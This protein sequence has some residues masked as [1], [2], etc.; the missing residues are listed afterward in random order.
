[1]TGWHVFPSGLTVA[2]CYWNQPWCQPVAF[3]KICADVSA[4]SQIVLLIDQINVPCSA[5]LLL[6]LRHDALPPSALLL[7]PL[8]VRHSKQEVP[9]MSAHQC[10]AGPRV[11]ITADVDSSPVHRVQAGSYRACAKNILEH[12]V[13]LG[14]LLP[15]GWGG[16]IMSKI[17]PF[18]PSLSLLFS[19]WLE[20]GGSRVV[21]VEGS[22]VDPVL[23]Q[24]CSASC[25]TC[26]VKHGKH[27]HSG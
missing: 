12:I 18:Q 16:R 13:A 3:A 15:E 24:R 8:L 4:G 2:R 20:G 5:R 26:S 7:L 22:G 9:Q 1:M 11:W 17:R 19:D 27:P 6:S 25:D 14:P 21:R 23:G 10:R